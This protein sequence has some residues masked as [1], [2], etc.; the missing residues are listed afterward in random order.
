M[1]CLAL[2][3]ALEQ[4]VPLPRRAAE[5]AGE[6]NI[7]EFLDRWASAHPRKAIDGGRA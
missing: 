5:L 1:R 3:L 7:A 6:T 4:G 2:R